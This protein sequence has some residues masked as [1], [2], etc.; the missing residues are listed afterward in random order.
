MSLEMESIPFTIY[1]Q[2]QLTR[3]SLSERQLADILQNIS[4]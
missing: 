4:I 1:L 2:E 3:S